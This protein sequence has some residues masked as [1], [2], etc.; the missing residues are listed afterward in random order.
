M[1]KFGLIG[2][3][4]SHSFSQKFFTGKF[5]RE[6][7]N[8]CVYQNFPIPSINGFRTILSENPDLEGLNVTIPYKQLVIPL[9]DNHAGTLP[10]NAC[11]CIKIRNGRTT[12]YNTDIIGF[13]KTLTPQL[14]SFHRNALIL[15]NGGAAIAVQYVLKKLNIDFKIVSRKIHDGAS[16]T[17][18]DL[19]ADIILQHLLIINTTPLGMYPRIEECPPI[20]YEFIT[21]KHYLYDLIYNPT[22]T[23]F[24]EKGEQKNASIKNG[25]EMLIIQAEESWRIWNEAD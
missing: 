17:Y 2:Y 19:N 15:G 6:N 25:E 8:D 12:G 1:R 13:E 21:E 22:K 7:R 10:V 9:L 18:E 24:L 14:K 11:N 3:P 4:L 5:M 20:P 16:F 23:L